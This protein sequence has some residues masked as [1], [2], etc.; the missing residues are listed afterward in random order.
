MLISSS[1]EEVTGW[2]TTEDWRRL[3]AGERPTVTLS[4]EDWQ[5]QWW[6][7]HR[8]QTCW[9][10]AFGP[11]K[12]TTGDGDALAERLLDLGAG[13]LPLDSDATVEVLREPAV[14]HLLATLTQAAVADSEQRP[15]VVVADVDGGAYG[16]FTASHV[17]APLWL[18]RYGDGYVALD[19]PHAHR[20]LADGLSRW[21]IDTLN[22]PPTGVS[23]PSG[24]AGA[25]LDPNPVPAGA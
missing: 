7:W 22:A 19:A 25:S 21:V 15:V 18:T 8:W 11:V 2:V 4:H 5:G 13:G 1:D 3:W 16:A 12:V 10:L 20:L 6:T 9:P 17:S 14:G 23:G 24:A